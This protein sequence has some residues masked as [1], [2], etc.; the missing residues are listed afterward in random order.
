[1]DGLERFRRAQERAHAGFE[2]ALAELQ[3]GHKQS[4]WIWYVF[5]QLAGLGSSHM[6]QTYG[7]EGVDEAMRY[8]QD[9]GL[10]SRLRTIAAAA[11]GHARRGVPLARLMGARIDALKLV[12]SMTLFAEVARRCH[13]AE[14]LEEYEAVARMAEEILAI[15]EGQGYPACQFTRARLREL[16]DG[17]SRSP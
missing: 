16:T 14:G 15:A 10:R 2:V 17:A 7:L 11:A 1:M 9:P 13:A 6:A 12:S 8:L 5:P 3:A 4:H